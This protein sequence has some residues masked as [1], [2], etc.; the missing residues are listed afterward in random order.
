VATHDEWAWLVTTEILD[1]YVNVLR[2]PKFGLSPEEL[3]QWTDVV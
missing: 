3:Q 1:E 2:R